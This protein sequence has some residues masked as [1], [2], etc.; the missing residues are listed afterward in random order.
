MTPDI[1]CAT[2]GLEQCQRALEAGERRSRLLIEKNADGVIVVRRDGVICYANPAAA[3]L[4]RRSARQLIGE[5]FGIPV[6]P[7]ETTE[8]DIPHAN[9]STRVAEM[10]V[11]EIEWEGEPA[12]LASLRDITER[13]RA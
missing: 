7:G 6:L 9:K 2:A 5:M 10:R 12:F 13:R 8:L 11:A 4:L 3:T 1:T